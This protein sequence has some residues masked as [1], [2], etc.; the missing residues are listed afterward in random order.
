MAFTNRFSS[1][2]TLF[3]RL[4]RQQQCARRVANDKSQAHPE[5]Q[6]SK[7]L[8]SIEKQGVRENLTPFCFLQY[9]KVAPNLHPFSKSHTACPLL[10]AVYQYK[11]DLLLFNSHRF[12]IQLKNTFNFR[13][14][15]LRLKA[16]PLHQ[17]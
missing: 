16:L 4:R 3:H 14:L 11:K 10:L 9:F 7:S 17:I 5:A 2:Y 15:Q 1:A 6:K 12:S 13:Q 8:H